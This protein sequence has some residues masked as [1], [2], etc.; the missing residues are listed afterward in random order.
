MSNSVVIGAKLYSPVLYSN[1]KSNLAYADIEYKLKVIAEL[2]VGSFVIVWYVYDY[3]FIE[4][5]HSAFLGKPFVDA[6]NI[7]DYENFYKYLGKVNKDVLA[8]NKKLNKAVKT[9]KV[10]FLFSLDVL[11]K[12]FETIKED[13]LFCKD[14]GV[15]FVQS[16]AEPG[17]FL[18]DYVADQSSS[19]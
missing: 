17:Y 8:V 18:E 11:A 2:T 3:I 4:D 1:V 9:K 13:T 19:F 7:E 6:L 14:S 12:Y 10:D 16:Y 15:A 5:K